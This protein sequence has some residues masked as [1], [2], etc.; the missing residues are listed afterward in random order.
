MI[1][2]EKFLVGMQDTDKNNLIT[3]KALLEYMGNVACLHSNF[4]GTGP[5]QIAETNLSWVIVNWKVEVKNRPEYFEHFIVKTWSRGYDRLY[6]YR[7][8]EITDE[9]G[10]QIAVA[11]S[12]CAMVDTA[13]HKITR[14]NPEIMDK[15]GTE[16]KQMIPG[17]EFPKI[18]EF[19]NFIKEGNY[20]IN[21][22]MIDFNNHVHNTSYL[23]LADEVI[24]EEYINNQFNNFEIIYKKEIKLNDNV[25]LRYSEDSGKK[26]VTI[27]SEDET[28]THSQIIFL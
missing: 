7:D 22:M 10:N 18:K 26:Y 27:K 9:A 20:K 11:T 1:F 12:R 8:F 15:Y 14:L 6:A 21:S 19:E 16:T 17:Y 5:K 3:N 13:K 23:D 28:I 4:A 24:P 25:L 2:E